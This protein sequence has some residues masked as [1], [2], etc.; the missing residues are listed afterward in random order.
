M[1]NGA[2]IMVTGGTGSFARAFVARVLKDNP[3]RLV[4]YSRGEHAQEEMAR[5][6]QH[7][8]LRFFIGDVRDVERLTMAMRDIEIVVHTAALK[9][10][11]TLEYN[12]IEAIR[13][14]IIGAQN[15]ILAAMVNKVRK[16]LALSTDK[17]VNATNLYGSTKHCAEC[18]FTSAHSMGG[19]G[20]PLFSVV[21]YGNVVGSR[22]SVVP[23]FEKLAEQ[24]CALPITD[25]RMTRFI[26]TMD[27]AVNFVLGCLINMRGEEI[28]IPRIPSIKIM[29]LAKAV[30]SKHHP[31]LDDARHTC[32]IEETGVRPGEKLHEV[33]L[34]TDEAPRTTQL[35]GHFIIKANG[36]GGGL[37]DGF[38]YTSDNN[39]DWLS[40][41]QFREMI[42]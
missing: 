35:A 19:S 36:K 33:L 13:T 23:R 11:P 7:P 9:I 5:E 18:L 40:V 1:I 6:F 28:F 27:Q 22:G 26:I 8:S 20:G 21:R 39:S 38:S 42:T 37:P 32:Q 34:S 31:G 30:W 16:V 24:G 25:Q 10:V 12:P 29:D 14:N 17:A 41:G 15:V 4:L 2:S 3:R